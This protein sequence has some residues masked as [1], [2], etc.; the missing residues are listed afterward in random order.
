M[1]PKPEILGIVRG[2]ATVGIIPL[3]VL[4]LVLKKSEV[5]AAH[6]SYSIGTT[7]EV[8][9]LEVVGVY[10]NILVDFLTALEIEDELLHG[11]YHALHINASVKKVRSRADKDET[12]IVIV[13]V[14]AG[15]EALNV[16]KSYS[17][18]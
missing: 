3:K 17:K 18:I 14:N 16:L 4:L 8:G 1:Y 2:I 13:T 15:E 6:G 11:L 7:V 12:H 9:V 5:L 10:L